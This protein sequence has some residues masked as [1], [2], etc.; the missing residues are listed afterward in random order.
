MHKISGNACS[1]SP[2]VKKPHGSFTNL[3]NFKK[4]IASFLNL[5]RIHKPFENLQNST[6]LSKIPTF[7]C[8]SCEDI[9]SLLFYRIVEASEHRSLKNCTENPNNFQKFSKHLRNFTKLFE[10]S[11][12]F[13]EVSQTSRKLQCLLKLAGMLQK[14]HKFLGFPQNF[15]K[16]CGVFQSFQKKFK[17]Y[18]IVISKCNLRKFQKCSIVEHQLMEFPI[19][20]C[21]TEAKAL[22]QN[23]LK[24]SKSFVM[25]RG[26]FMK[27]WRDCKTYVWNLKTFE[28]KE[29]LQS[30]SQ[31]I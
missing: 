8:Y 25:L 24:L 18:R 7:H 10:S 3:W 5:L 11:G 31:K 2:K 13:V 6:K 14:F 27:H 23:F 21:V 16:P 30:N 17:S 28:Q 29:V 19:T 26:S 15:R 12:I 9:R 1:S 22:S 4:G 20:I